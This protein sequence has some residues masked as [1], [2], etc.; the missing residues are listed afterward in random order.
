MNLCLSSG[1]QEF[2]VISIRLRPMAWAPYRPSS[3]GEEEFWPPS[4]T[5]IYCLDTSA[6]IPPGAITAQNI[7]LKN[8]TTFL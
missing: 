8:L 4:L 5:L 1:N 6:S 2:T 7:R 3:R